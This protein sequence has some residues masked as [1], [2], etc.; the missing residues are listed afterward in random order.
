MSS[1]EESY[2]FEDAADDEIDKDKLDS[3]DKIDDKDFSIQNL[4]NL[5]QFEGERKS[6]VSNNIS[7]SYPIMYSIYLVIFIVVA[8]N[9]ASIYSSFL[10]LKG[11]SD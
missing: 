10:V 5:F 4:N 1:I 7:L 9:A 6:V 8:F 11:M 3:A 2:V